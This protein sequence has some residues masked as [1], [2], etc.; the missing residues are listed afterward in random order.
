[1]DRVE[2]Q[3]AES[4]QVKVTATPRSTAYLLAV[5]QSV[6]LLKSG[7]DITQEQASSHKTFKT[8]LLLLKVA[9]RHP[10]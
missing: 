10:L 5:D 6:L 1:M 2:A 9:C 3:P 8:L 7:N 4:V